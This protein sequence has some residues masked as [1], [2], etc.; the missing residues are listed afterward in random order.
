MVNNFSFDFSENL[1]D[2]AVRQEQEMKHQESLLEQQREHERQIE[3]RLK[4]QHEAELYQET[5][6]KSIQEEVAIKTQRLKEVLF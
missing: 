1:L 5:Q 3:A 6:F 4:E 2:K